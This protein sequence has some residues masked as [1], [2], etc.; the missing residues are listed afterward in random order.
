MDNEDKLADEVYD[1]QQDVQ[2]LKETI[3]DL[4]NEQSEA[5]NKLDALQDEIK[6]GYLYAIEQLEYYDLLEA[7]GGGIDE[8]KYAQY[9]THADIFLNLYTYFDKTNSLF[10]SNRQAREKAKK[11]VESHKAP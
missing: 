1:L 5:E 8:E 11:R 3:T 7:N 6:E 2:E 4:Q 9:V 10:Q